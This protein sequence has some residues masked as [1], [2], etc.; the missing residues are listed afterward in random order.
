L[1]INVI[2]ILL[3]YQCIL[4]PLKTKYKL[5]YAYRR[6]SYRAVNNLHFGYRNQFVNAVYENNYFVLRFIRNTQIKIHRMVKCGVS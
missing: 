4:S 1:E 3:Q 6:N 2:E 5:H